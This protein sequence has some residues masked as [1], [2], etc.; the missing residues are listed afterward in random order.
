MR[1][2]RIQWKWVESFARVFSLCGVQR[3]EVSAILSESQSRAINVELAEL[4]LESLGATVFHISLP[5]PRLTAPVPVRSTGASHVLQRIAPVVDS[6]ARCGFIA[7]LTDEGLL[8]APELGDILKGG[9]RILVVSNE[10]PEILERTMPDP[11]LEPKVRLGMRM[12]KG[13]REMHVTSRHGSD[14]RVAMEGARVGGVWGYTAKP[15]TISHWPGGICLA[16]PKAG[17]ANGRLVLAPGDIN[18]TFKRYLETPVTLNIVDDYITAIDGD[19]IDAA[20]TRDYL[21]A[22]KDR[23]AAAVSHVGWGMNPGAH[24]V[25]GIMY[26]KD[27]TNGT[28]QR[29][30]A[31]NFLYSTGANETANRF[32]LGHF[33]IPMRGCSVSLDGTPVVIEGALVGELA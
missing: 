33:D 10:H 4:A 26:D 7:D 2:D 19:G 15:G 12:M 13:A 20:L 22:W 9:A 23:N 29:A 27:E 16:F 5:T 18:L 21:S 24:W 28:E 6:L 25:S 3:G 17:A 31:G 32:T 1:N 30:F 14:L 8:H 11:A